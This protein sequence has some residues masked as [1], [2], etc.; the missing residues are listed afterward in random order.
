MPIIDGPGSERWSDFQQ[1]KDA[2][3]LRGE[4]DLDHIKKDVVI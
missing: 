2:L 4:S 1:P 3:A